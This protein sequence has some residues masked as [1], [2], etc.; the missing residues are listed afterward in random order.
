MS[1]QL[2][3]RVLSDLH[4][5]HP[6]S[7]VRNVWQLVPL[8]EGARTAVFNG[9]TAELRLR[10]ARQ[11]A[12]RY[13]GTVR[14]MCEER[15]IEPVF[16]TGNHD[17]EAS[18]KHHLELMGGTIMI[19]HGDVLFP[20]ITPWGRDAKGLLEN[21]QRALA[22]AAGGSDPTWEDL[23]LAAKAASLQTEPPAERMPESKLAWIRA[24]FREQSHPLR[25]LH[26]LRAWATAPARA[27]SLMAEHRPEVRWF[28]S[29]HTHLPGMWRRGQL[30]ILNTGAYL[31]WLGRSVID[32]SDGRIS[33]RRVVAEG[34]YFRPGREIF[35]SSL[36]PEGEGTRQKMRRGDKI[37]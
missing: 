18:D 5:A 2:P 3:L 30:T 17:P 29:G 27:A 37:V 10:G 20:E 34:N 25:A 16:L 26:V 23:L 4:L 14:A 19:T 32:I 35:V 9:D 6:A 36:E 7:L 31:P 24:L 33:M 28:I 8:L 12:E 13:F 21:R 22:Q 11:T 15:G 1:L